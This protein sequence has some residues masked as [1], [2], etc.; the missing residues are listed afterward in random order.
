M[1]IILCF[2]LLDLLYFCVYFEFNLNRIC[3][4]DLEIFYRVGGVKW[5]FDFVGGGGGLSYFFIFINKF[6]F[7]RGVGGLG[8]TDFFLGFFFRFVYVEFGIILVFF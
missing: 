6:N 7:V 4:V 3:G 5:L 1:F 2:I 8:L